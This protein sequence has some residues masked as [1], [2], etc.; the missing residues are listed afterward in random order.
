MTGKWSDP[1]RDDMSEEKDARVCP[2]C[3][4]EM[5][6]RNCQAFESNCHNL[7]LQC[8]IAVSLYTIAG[9]P[10]GDGH[11][12]DFMCRCGHEEKVKP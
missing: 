1:L 5:E 7:E 4:S 2:K 10:F 9:T 12:S 6:C 3:G 8:G 11:C